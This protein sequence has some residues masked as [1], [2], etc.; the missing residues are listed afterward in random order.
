MSRLVFG[1]RVGK[2]EDSAIAWTILGV[3]MRCAMSTSRNVADCPD[4]RGEADR[5]VFT[6][7]TL[8]DPRSLLLSRRIL[9]SSFVLVMSGSVVGRNLLCQLPLP[10]LYKLR[11]LEQGVIPS[12]T[13]S[14]M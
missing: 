4:G 3:S 12:I 7:G 13:P 10:C 6:P 1:L 14:I 11:L 8:C 9:P 5:E 2:R